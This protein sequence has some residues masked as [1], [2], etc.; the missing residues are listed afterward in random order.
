[1]Q[2]QYGDPDF[3]FAD[4]LKPFVDAPWFVAATASVCLGLIYLVACYAVVGALT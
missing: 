1:M 2:K 4:N 3:E